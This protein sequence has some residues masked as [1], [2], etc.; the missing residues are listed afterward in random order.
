[1]YLADLLI[2]WVQGAILTWGFLLII[3]PEMPEEEQW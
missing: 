2:Y 3:A 1:M